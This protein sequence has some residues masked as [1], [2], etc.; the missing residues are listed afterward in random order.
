[1]FLPEYT[2]NY[3]SNLYYYEFYDINMVLKWLEYEGGRPE[4]AALPPL[5]PDTLENKITKGFMI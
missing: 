2:Y 3:D 1:M 4:R 5:G